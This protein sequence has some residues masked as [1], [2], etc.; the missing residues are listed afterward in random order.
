MVCADIEHRGHLQLL[1]YAQGQ[2]GGEGPDQ[3]GKI[4]HV[5]HCSESFN[6]ASTTIPWY[7]YR[8]N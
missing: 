2:A 5:I 8:I 1:W 3:R 6:Y 7:R 4:G